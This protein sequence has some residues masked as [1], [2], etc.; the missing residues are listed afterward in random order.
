MPTVYDQFTRRIA[1]IT[2]LLTAQGIPLTAPTAPRADPTDPWAASWPVP[3]DRSTLAWCTAVQMLADHHHTTIDRQVPAADALLRELGV[4]GLAELHSDLHHGAPI[5]YCYT[6]CPYCSGIGD[7]PTQPTCGKAGCPQ[8]RDVEDGHEHL[9]PVCV[10]QDHDPQG[11]ATHH[12][13]NLEELLADAMRSTP[14]L[15][16][17]L[18]RA[19]GR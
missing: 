3:V 9:C 14:R 17:A 11:H 10:G 2:T 13:G 4:R 18:G 16:S 12:M 1:D 8:G 19:V 5:D 7:D 6:R 15:L